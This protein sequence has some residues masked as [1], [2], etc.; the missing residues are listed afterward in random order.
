MRHNKCAQ[1]AEMVHVVAILCR[2]ERRP[3]SFNQKNTWVLRRSILLRV[4][5]KSAP[6]TIFCAQAAEI[7][8]V[9]HCSSADTMHTL[10][11]YLQQKCVDT[12]FFCVSCVRVST[13]TVFAFAVQAWRSVRVVAIPRKREHRRI[14]F[15]QKTN[16]LTRCSDPLISVGGLFSMI[17]QNRGCLVIVIVEGNQIS[18]NI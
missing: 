1:V 13:G 2:R 7:V 16:V 4:L 18:T 8:C 17:F 14:H 6:E 3:I 12:I 5:G 10:G 9:L 11:E 15:H